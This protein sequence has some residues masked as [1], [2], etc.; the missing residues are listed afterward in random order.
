MVTLPTELLAELLDL[1]SLYKFLEDKA[2]NYKHREIADL[3]QRIRDKMQLEKKADLEAI[4]QWETNIFNFSFTGN[5]ATPSNVLSDSEGKL[6]RYPRYENFVPESYDYI[7]ERLKSTNNPV[8][9]AQYA[10]FLWFSPK[11]HG[12]Y[13]QLAIDSY[14]ELIKLYEMKDIENPQKHFGFDVIRVVEN[15]FLLSRN[16]SDATKIDL[17][18]KEIKRLIFNFN[19][20][21]TSLFRL[22]LDLLG[23]MIREKAILTKDDFNG[24]NDVCFNFSKSLVEK[25]QEHQAISI[26]QLGKLIDEKAKT[27]KYNWNVLIAESFEKLMD[28]NLQNNKHVAIEFC[29]EALESYRHAKKTEMIKEKIEKLE[30]IYTDL[31][32]SLEFPVT[33]VM[34]DLKDFIA[35]CEKRTQEIM[36]LTSEQ[37][38]GFIMTDKSF[39]PSYQFTKELT[40]KIS[41]KYPLHTIFPTSQI[42]GQ[43]HKSQSFITPEEIE[44]FNILQHYRMIIENYCGR[45]L[46]MVFI[47][48]VKENKI[49]YETLIEFFA[50]YSWFGKTI[51]KMRFNKEVPYN[52]LSLLAPSLLE[53]FAQMD[54]WMASGNYPNLILCID[55][56]ILKIEGLLRDMCYFKGIATFTSRTDKKN[57]KNIIHEK[58]LNALLSEKR[59][60]ELFDK[61][62]LLLFKFV[63]IEKSGYNLRHKIA[64]SLMLSSEYSVYYAHLL[65]LILLKIGSFNLTMTRKTEVKEKTK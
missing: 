23:L 34:I 37:I 40:Q 45:F 27:D 58:E 5:V 41:K 28:T 43:G 29:S 22:R 63:L 49:T 57:G 59:L 21:S 4:A 11:K 24:L 50:K 61:D 3:F 18:K 56:L 53:Y 20:V 10:H 31:S 30:S 46:N 14:F 7:V 55:S 54:Y 48:S 38:I 51:P 9:K 35:D 42:D 12:K 13:A 60:A 64:H 8:L 6:V 44:Y 62:D 52:W 15:A 16:I 32:K 1:D 19:A 36:K 47:E 39:L 65:L 25:H 33:E 17:A 26:M 2:I